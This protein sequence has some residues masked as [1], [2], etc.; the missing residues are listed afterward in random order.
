MR[1]MAKWA[2]LGEDEV[3]TQAIQRRVLRASGLMVDGNLSLHS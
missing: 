1:V 2:G 3:L